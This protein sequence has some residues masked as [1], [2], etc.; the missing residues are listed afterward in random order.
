MAR[1]EERRGWRRGT[2]GA[3]TRARHKKSKGASGAEQSEA[4]ARESRMCEWTNEENTRDTPP[5]IG[6]EAWETSEWEMLGR[7]SDERRKARGRAP[8]EVMCA[9][10]ARREWG[11]AK[12]DERRA[13]CA[14]GEKNATREKVVGREEEKDVRPEQARRRAVR[15]GREERER[16]SG[17]WSGEQP[18]TD[19]TCRIALNK[20]NRGL[21]DDKQP[22]PQ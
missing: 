7:T 13:K 14:R 5:Y 12:G 11:D 21:R 4:R 22:D 17:K 1:H 15:N 19:T 20:G 16:E 10:A 9:A 6:S 2:R 8:W 3:E 18:S